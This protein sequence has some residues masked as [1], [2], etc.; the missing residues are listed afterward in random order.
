M[1]RIIHFI[2]LYVFVHFNTVDNGPIMDIFFYLLENQ[3]MPSNEESEIIES[4]KF[5]YDLTGTSTCAQLAGCK[6]V[7]EGVGCYGP[8]G[9]FLNCLKCFQ[10]NSVSSRNVMRA[11]FYKFDSAYLKK[12]KINS[13][14]ECPSI[15]HMKEMIEHMLLEGDDVAITYQGAPWKSYSV[16]KVKFREHY[17]AKFCDE[18]CVNELKAS[19]IR[20]AVLPSVRRWCT[21]ALTFIEDKIDKLRG[22]PSYVLFLASRL[23]AYSNYLKP[24]AKISC[25][26]DACEWPGANLEAEYEEKAVLVAAACCSVLLAGDW[27]QESSFQPNEKFGDFGFAVQHSLWLAIF[28]GRLRLTLQ[29]NNALKA[30]H[31]PG[32]RTM[33]DEKAVS[34]AENYE[35]STGTVYAALCAMFPY[36]GGR[37]EQLRYQPEIHVLNDQGCVEK[38][39]GM[40]FVRPGDWMVNNPRYAKMGSSV[41]P[42]GT[43]FY[44]QHNLTTI[45]FSHSGATIYPPSVAVSLNKE[46]NTLCTCSVDCGNGPNY[47][48][49]FNGVGLRGI[50]GIC[51]WVPVW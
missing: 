7:A 45:E 17:D 23:A 8:S 38:T 14:N 20:P 24:S 34:M 22:P 4:K 37:I 16:P 50:G 26:G 32:T 13:D 6:T 19:C 5:D 48:G 31:P 9:S 15:P 51:N 43:M 47:G 27:W 18:H 12:C 28:A 44:D 39:A 2:L 41:L 33:C 1:A 25:G 49:L 3:P 40:I 36:S 46:K 21:T 30:K 29:P 10:F 11:D 42:L 35:G